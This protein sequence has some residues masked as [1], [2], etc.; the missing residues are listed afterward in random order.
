M[1]LVRKGAFARLWWASAASSWGDWITFFATLALADHI[2]GSTAVL[3]PLVSRIIPSLLLGP[4]AGVLADRFDRKWTMVASDAGRA[5]VVLWLVLANDL[6]TIA[7]IS[8]ILEILT[9]VRQPA[10]EAAVP[11]LVETEQLV[12]ANSFSAAAAYGTAP[13]GAA[14]WSGVAALYAVLGAV[15]PIDRAPDLAFVLDSVTFLVSG[16]IVATIAIPK[17]TLADASGARDRAGRDWSQ[18]LRDMVEGFAFVTRTRTVRRVVFGMAVALFGGSALLPLGQSFAS[19][20]LRGGDTGFGVLV[21]ALG[22]GVGVGMMGVAVFSSDRTRYDL[23]YALS[24]GLAGLAIALAAFAQTISGAAGWVLVG[25]IG[26]GVAYVTGF[27]HLH[28]EVD[29]T[30]RGRTFAALFTLVR[31]AMLASFALAVV[32]ANALDGIF[33]APFDSG[34]RNLFAISGVLILGTGSLLILAIRSALLKP[35]VPPEVRRSIRDA[36]RAFGLMRGRRGD[37]GYR[38]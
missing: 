4:L 10:R 19:T 26:T 2:G 12:K 7:V 20:V 13:I 24:L 30:L 37:S 8:S 18:P 28:G 33:P 5:V 22:V 32:V 9:M 35:D 14:T 29:D 23:T 34:I 27:T 1:E 15:G 16:A 38:D 11:T 36:S 6:V 21:T 3:V 31:M 25:G 17:P